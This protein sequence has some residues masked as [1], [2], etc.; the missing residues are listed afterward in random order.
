[1]VRALQHNK[2]DAFKE[3]YRSADA[4]LIDDIQFLL[5]KKDLKKNF[6]IPLILFWKEIARLY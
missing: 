3:F 4:L 2:I 5:E 1:M 6:F